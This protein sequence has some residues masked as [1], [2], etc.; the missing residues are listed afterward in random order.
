MRNRFKFDLVM[1]ASP[2]Q[3][4]KL[5]PDWADNRLHFILGYWDE[6]RGGHPFPSRADIDPLDFA[7]HWPLVY[8]VEGSSLPSLK[9]RLA[10]TAYRDL[11][12]FEITGRKIVDLIPRMQRR[13]VV[14]DYANCLERG[15]PIFRADT[16]TWRP[17][18]AKIS[19]HRV[20]L[21]LGAPCGLVTHE[22]ALAVFFD[23]NGQAM[24]V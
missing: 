17:Q 10:G 6:M 16:M 7:P 13:D 19:Y 20:L 9:I 23:T 14:D 8:L 11:Y 2:K 15:Q 24:F 22:L 1:A 3:L 5:V 12:G 18:N 4:E 21:P